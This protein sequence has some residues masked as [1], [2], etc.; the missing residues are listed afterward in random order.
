M[1]A[2][3]ERSERRVGEMSRLDL[4]ELRAF[5]AACE[6]PSGASPGLFVRSI[7]RGPRL[8]ARG[9]R[10]DPHDPVLPHDRHPVR[11]I[12][13]GDHD[14]L[15]DEAAWGGAGEGGDQ[16]RQLLPVQPL[17]MDGGIGL[18]F[19]GGVRFDR[20]VVEQGVTSG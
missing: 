14:A 7:S 6:S 15:D 10:S 18:G 4:A 3:S 1:P 17:L 8:I 19:K 12:G 11:V 5:A 20:D 16:T 13:Q 9:P 2:R